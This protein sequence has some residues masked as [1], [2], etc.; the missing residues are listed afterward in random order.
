MKKRILVLFICTSFSAFASSIFTMEL[1]NQLI[2]A[3]KEGTEKNITYLLQEGAEPNF[4]D[5]KG[6]SAFVWAVLRGNP[7]SSLKILLDNGANINLQDFEGNT[8][9]MYA[10]ERFNFQPSS[11]R[12][13][14]K[15]LL[16]HGANLTIKNEKNKTA[17]DIAKEQGYISKEA[18]NI[19]REKGYTEIEQ[20]LQTTK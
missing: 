5:A 12:R 7:L 9:L 16:E 20:I 17:L 13:Q 14:I 3:A 19:A 1:N 15:F 2:Q 8:A 18:G 10:I 11:A 6:I 4:Q